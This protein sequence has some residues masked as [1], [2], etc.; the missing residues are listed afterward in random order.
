MPD[1]VSSGIGTEKKAVFL[2]REGF[3]FIEVHLALSKWEKLR[4]SV[5]FL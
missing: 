4:A 3:D 2:G 5:F 1:S